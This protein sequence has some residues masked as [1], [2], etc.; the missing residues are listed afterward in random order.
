MKKI[1]ATALLL[2][3]INICITA[4]SHMKSMEQAA[5]D[6]LLFRQLHFEKVIG[7]TVDLKL[8]AKYYAALKQGYQGYTNRN[9]IV[10]QT[11][12]NVAVNSDPIYGHNTSS[13]IDNGEDKK[14]PFYDGEFDVLTRSYYRRTLT[15]LQI[16]CLKR[17]SVMKWNGDLREQYGNQHGTYPYYSANDPR[18][19]RRRAE[20]KDLVR[21]LEMF[22][23]KAS[24]L[25]IFFTDIESKYGGNI[26]K[27]VR[28]LYGKTIMGSLGNLYR[29]M[30]APSAEA[31]QS[32][33]GVQYAVGL[34]LYELWIKDVREGRVK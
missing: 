24:H 14:P 18:R 6:T 26:R 31:I 27:Y 7:P 11:E 10:R 12:L 17:D 13:L 9:K 22:R 3:S 21:R 30:N 5:K 33:L 25:P 15:P 2:C 19:Y 32:D 1:L 28:H 23:E 4:Q 34:A 20:M 8:F 16:E 29:F